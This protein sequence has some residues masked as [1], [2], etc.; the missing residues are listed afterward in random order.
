[1]RERAVFIDDFADLLRNLRA[2]E[3]CRHLARR[4]RIRKRRRRALEPNVDDSAGHEVILA[5]ADVDVGL[6]SA[7]DLP[8]KCP[9]PTDHA[10]AVLE[11]MVAEGAITEEERSRMAENKIFS[12]SSETTEIS[13][14]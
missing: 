7:A 5:I 9:L 8:G 13:S 11:E 6:I 10:N 3:E 4:S 12:P 2:R 14:N 1:M